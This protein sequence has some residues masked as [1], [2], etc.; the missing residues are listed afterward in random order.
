MAKK[1]KPGQEPKVFPQVGQRWVEKSG[2]IPHELL[3]IRRSQDTASKEV[4]ECDDDYTDDEGKHETTR[5]LYLADFAEP[6]MQCV[7]DPKEP[8]A[9]PAPVLEVRMVPIKNGFTFKCPSPNCGDTHDEEDEM[10]W[11]ECQAA[12]ER[13]RARHAPHM[14]QGSLFGA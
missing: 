10:S 4:W 2:E 3:V 5:S 9:I 12:Y 11:S 6:F 8:A 7:H 14:D 13:F 1:A